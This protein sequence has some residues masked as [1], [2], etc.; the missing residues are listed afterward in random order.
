VP[1]AA[2][3]PRKVV[4]LSQWEHP[5][6]CSSHRRSQAPGAVWFSGG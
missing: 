5:G 3:T 4:A 6:L 2:Q 1:Q